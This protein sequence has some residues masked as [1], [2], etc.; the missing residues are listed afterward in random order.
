MNKWQYEDANIF[1][2]AAAYAFFDGNKRT[3]F[4]KSATFLRLNGWYLMTEPAGTW[5]NRNQITLIAYY[6]RLWYYGQVGETFLAQKK[7]DLIK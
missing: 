2:C 5:F 4:V 6:H 1:E 3:A 7:E